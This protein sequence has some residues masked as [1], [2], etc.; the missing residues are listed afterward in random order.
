MGR[1]MVATIAVYLMVV[2]APV[3]AQQADPLGLAAGGVVL[4]FFNSNLTGDTSYLEIAS[5]QGPSPGM[6]AVF[7]FA[8]C[9]RINAVTDLSLIENQTAL[10][11]IIPN[12]NGLVTIASLNADGFPAPLAAPIHTRVYWINAAS[13]RGHILEPITVQQ[14]GGGSAT[15]NPLRTGATFFAPSEPPGGAIHT[16][17]YL[18]CPKTSIQ[19]AAG[20]ALPAGTF[21]AISPPFL[22]D[23]IGGLRARIYDANGQFLTNIS[24]TCDCLVEQRVAALHSV[25]GNSNHGGTYTE[26]ESTPQA[27]FAFTG[28]RAI[29]IDGSPFSLFGRLSNNSRLD[30]GGSTSSPNNR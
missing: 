18:I 6:Q 9:A 1:S 11:P 13:G 22:A 24:L 8:S 25:Y 5:P 21:P 30:A 4:P 26:L 29:N 2:A 27:S 7:F 20:S 10:L 19:G 3:M 14:P 17:L 15:W 28:Y 16:V 23:Y 12:A